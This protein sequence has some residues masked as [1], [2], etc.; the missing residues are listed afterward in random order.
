MTRYRPAILPDPLPI[1]PKWIPPS[2]EDLEGFHYTL[3]F[4]RGERN[5]LKKRRPI[6]PSRWVE[7]HRVLPRDAAIPGKWRNETTP[8]LTGIMD[9]SF[10]PSVQVIIVCAPPQTG[11]SEFV[12]NCIGY[13]TDRKPGNVLVI[14]PDELTAKENS[15]DR[16]Q[17][18]FLDS[19]RLR[20]YLTGNA[21][22]LSNYRIQLRH[23]RIYLGWANSAARLGNKPL[24]YVVEDEMDKYPETAG[25]KEASPDALAKKRTRT[26]T[27]MRKIWKISTPTIESGPITVALKEEAEVVFEYWVRCPECGAW[28]LMDFD[29]IKWPPDIRDHRKI[30]SSK[31]ARYHCKSCP[32]EWD[33]DT[34][35]QAVRLGQWRDR[36]KGLSLDTCLAA[37][38]PRA[39]GF[40]YPSWIAPFVSLS[41]AASAF[42]KGLKDKTALKD[43]M[44][45][46]KAEPWVIKARERKEDRILKLRDDRPRGVVPGGGVVAALTAAV[47][48]QDEK[49]GFWYEIRAW[50]Y[51]L[52]QASWQIREGLVTTWEDLVRVLWEDKYLDADGKRYLVRLT[53]QDAMGNRTADVYD[54][55]RMHRG[56]I[57]ATKGEQRMNQPYAYTNL[58]FY[59]GTNKPIPGGLKLLR[60][61]TTHYKNTL[62]NKLDISPADPGAWHFHAETTAEWAM[63]MTAEYIDEKGNWACPSGRPN[64][65][66]D[67]SVLN[68]AAADV[69]G[70]RFWKKKQMDKNPPP[71]KAGPA[72]KPQ[73]SWLNRGG[74]NRPG[75]LNR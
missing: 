7:K 63:H 42:L 40:Q 31:L 54:F 36:D 8:Y 37:Y 12:N 34:R 17:T 13:A 75:W 71:K 70:I 21:D 65:G 47:D 5:V 60:L 30:L 59:P 67:C 26:F 22:D 73:S 45:A 24:P 3:R 1:D 49:V 35:N 43:F 16:L 64:H 57:L 2:F 20:T 74:Y 69:L 39:I 48:T 25:K 38:N 66:W 56:R 52:S 14:Y 27:H 32:A 6:Q 11:K 19:P 15:K 50:G 23:M 68:L 28:Q 46:H 53:L 33:D 61:N 51:G 18:M 4:S 29:Q 58:E 55:C 41:E 10:Y 62:S 44:N 72:P 9:A